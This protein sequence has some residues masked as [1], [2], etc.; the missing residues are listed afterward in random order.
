MEYF[1][2]IVDV[3]FVDVIGLSNGVV[4]FGGN[5]GVDREV[6]RSFSLL[7]R[8]S[9]GLTAKWW[10]LVDVF[11]WRDFERLDLGC[12]VLL[13]GLL[14][15]RGGRRQ[16]EL[17]FLVNFQAVCENRIGCVSAGLLGLQEREGSR[18]LCTSVLF[19]LTA[20]FTA[21]AGF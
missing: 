20:F 10:S 11:G 17:W 6:T 2:W 19:C 15:G 16:M 13:K 5:G 4:C 1:A 9:L 7:S 14:Q 3:M 18:R 8:F 21:I 12:S